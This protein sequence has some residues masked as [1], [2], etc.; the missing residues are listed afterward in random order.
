[1]SLIR[2]FWVFFV[3]LISMSSCSVGDLSI[4][5][6]LSNSGTK[7]DTEA[8]VSFAKSYPQV[9][10]RGTPNNWGTNKKMTLVNDNTWE[11]TAVFANTTNEL[12]KLDI[13]GNWTLNFG[14]N[15]ADSI[16]DQAG[17]DIKVS[18]SKCIL[19]G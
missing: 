13:Y 10:F 5:S 16:A 12:F 4:S 11:I 17:K 9:Y 8:T 14:D 3:T 1:M 19:F 6:G 15:N 7:F 2:N 18:W